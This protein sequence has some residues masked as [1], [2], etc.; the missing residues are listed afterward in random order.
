MINFVNLPPKQS[1]VN[2]SNKKQLYEYISFLFKTLFDVLYQPN[3]EAS[4]TDG[5][6]NVD[7]E[8]TEK[9]NN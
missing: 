6:S 5:S 2:L 3:V 8:N 7:K 1:R 4:A 9:T